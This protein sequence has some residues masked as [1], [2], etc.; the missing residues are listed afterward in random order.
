VETLEGSMTLTSLALAGNG[1]ALRKSV[2]ALLG[3]APLDATLREEGKLRVVT[4]DREIRIVPG[5]SL[6]VNLRA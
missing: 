4:F 1:K 3:Q 2:S 6:S 5:N